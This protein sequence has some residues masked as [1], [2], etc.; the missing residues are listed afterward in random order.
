MIFRRDARQTSTLGRHSAAH[1][2]SDDSRE[3]NKT[4]KIA[5][6]QAAGFMCQTIGPLESCAPDPGGRPRNRACVEIEGR[7]DPYDRRR[8]QAGDMSCHPLLLF[9]STEGYPHD[10]W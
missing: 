9:P 5:A 2:L 4:V 6:P 8:A 7:P 3:K 10:V 1:P